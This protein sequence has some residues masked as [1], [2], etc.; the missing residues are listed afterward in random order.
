MTPQRFPQRAVQTGSDARGSRDPVA[1]PVETSIAQRIAPDL[2]L[3]SDEPG[4]LL[5]PAHEERKRRGKS[6]PIGPNL[7]EKA[8]HE[9]THTS[10]RDWCS[11]C[12]RA[13][14]ADDPH[15]EHLRT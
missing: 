12:V 11:C 3:W 8:T 2:L 7:A 6:V 1:H 10:F 15:L 5:E 4:G 9:L 14:A 13:R